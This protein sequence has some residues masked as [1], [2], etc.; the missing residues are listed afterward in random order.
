MKLTLCI[1][2]DRI[3]TLKSWSVPIALRWKVDVT[4]LVNVCLC[5]VA[6]GPLPS[7]RVVIGTDGHAAS[8]I[9]LPTPPLSAL[10]LDMFGPINSH[11][12]AAHGRPTHSSKWCHEQYGCQPRVARD[13]SPGE[14][15][16]TS[17][18]SECS[19]TGIITGDFF[20]LQ[21]VYTMQVTGAGASKHAD[22]PA[23]P[24]MMS[25]KTMA[26]LEYWQAVLPETPMP[27]AIHDLLTQ[28]TGICIYLS[29]PPTSKKL[30]NNLALD[31]AWKCTVAGKVSC[32]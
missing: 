10:V 11:L 9:N 26:P 31:L 1:E 29:F 32:L 22:L 4:D 12:R 20:L 6:V 5:R 8:K 18:S 23:G 19:H 14:S 7:R 25:P 13:T 30:F 17:C 3:I 15:A 27:Q 2:G 24:A 21:R 16:L 28:S